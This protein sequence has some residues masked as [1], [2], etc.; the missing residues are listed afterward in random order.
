M[1]YFWKISIL[2]LI[3]VNPAFAGPEILADQNIMRLESALQKSQL[4]HFSKSEFHTNLV[5]VVRENVVANQQRPSVTEQ[6]DDKKN[7]SILS[8]PVGVDMPGGTTTELPP[9]DP[10]LPPPI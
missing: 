10:I 9:D 4:D 3:A 7:R 6:F 1:N 2:T 8:S 5:V